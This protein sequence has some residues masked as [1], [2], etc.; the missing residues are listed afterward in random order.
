MQL[1]E[2]LVTEQKEDKQRIEIEGYGNEHMIY[3]K[4]KFA[5]EEQANRRVEIKILGTEQ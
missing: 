2:H 3:P 1:K 5:A 4:A